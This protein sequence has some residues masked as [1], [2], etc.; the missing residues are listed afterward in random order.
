MAGGKI[1]INSAHASAL[2]LNDAEL[3][4][5]L[6]HEMQHALQEHN[7]K[8]YT[9][10]LRLFPAWRAKAF[11]ILEDAVDNDATLVRALA[12]LNFQQEIE[13]DAEGMK[14]AWRAGWP[15][16]QLA[17]YFKKLKRAS[18]MPNFESA[19]HP[20][21]ARRGQAARALA[22]DLDAINSKKIDTAPAKN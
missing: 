15:A 19:S 3:A 17:T 8:E 4:M 10:A 12:K 2:N 11:S 6:S 1:L 18:N 5:L 7:L 20:A 13:A 16:S 14:L 21:S 9:E 22:V